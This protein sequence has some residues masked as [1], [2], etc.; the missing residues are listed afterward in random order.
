MDDK[1][2]CVMGLV[3]YKDTRPK[4]VSTRYS[5]SYS[6]LKFYINATF[7][8]FIDW[9]YEKEFR[10]VLIFSDDIEKEIKVRE[11]DDFRAIDATIRNRYKGLKNDESCRYEDMLKEPI[12]D[13]DGES[14]LIKDMKAKVDQAAK[15]IK[16]DDADYKLW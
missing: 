14:K 16:K 11:S 10:F 2:G 1:G 12:S 6:D 7:T 3:S 8:K 5:F 13:P 4:Q 15:E 9:K